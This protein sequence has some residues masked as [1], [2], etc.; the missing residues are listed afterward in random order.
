MTNVEELLC[1]ALHEAHTDPRFALPPAPDALRRVRR[2]AHARR[3]RTAA[4]AAAGVAVVGAGGGYA[5][6]QLGGGTTTHLQ[7]AG[8]GPASGG[9]SSS[10]STTSPSPA[11]STQSLSPV[12]GI[13]P[14]WTPTSGTDWLMSRTELKQFLSTHRV[15]NPASYTA[16]SGPPPRTP[17]SARL[18]ADASSVLPNGTKLVREAAWDGLPGAAEFGATLPDG[19]FIDIARRQLRQPIR[20]DGHEEFG[21]RTRSPRSLP[22]GSAYAADAHADSGSRA[23]AVKV[24]TPHGEATTWYAP[25]SVPLKKLVRWAI[26]TDAFQHT[27]PSAPAS[28]PTR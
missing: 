7:Y 17:A 25:H 21:S 5:A 18:L 14:A 2:R 19:T 24:V 6:T 27:H 12:R 4:F 1:D 8:S 26:A 9:G 22:T 3:A 20:Y 28:A 15:P 11:S 23:K 10:G 16:S 13:S